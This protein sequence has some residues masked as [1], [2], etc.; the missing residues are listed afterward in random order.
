MM[1]FEK[2]RRDA[3][4]SRPMYALQDIP[5]PNL[6]REYFTYSDVPQIVFDGRSVPMNMADDIFI[7][8]TTFRDGQQAREPFTTG[9]IVDIYKLFHQ[10]GDRSGLVRQCEFFLY[11]DRDRKA[12][13]KCQELGYD[14]PEVTG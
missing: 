2:F 9:Q 3:A 10:L 8:D 1:E 4:H 13:E 7:T 14:F 6:Y 12:V 5:E 11:T